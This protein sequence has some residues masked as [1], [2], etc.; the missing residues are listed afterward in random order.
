MARP[1]GAVDQQDVLP[2]IPVV[3][4]KGAARAKRFRQELAAVGAVVVAECESGGGGDVGKLKP[5][6][7]PRLTIDAQWERRQ[8]QTCTATA[9]EIPAVDG[10]NGFTRPCWSA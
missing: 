10:H 7:S 8:A 1:I 5:R 2:P 4:E 9:K 6:R 3:V